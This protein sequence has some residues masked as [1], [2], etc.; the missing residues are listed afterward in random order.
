MSVAAGGKEKPDEPVMG[1][2]RGALIEE[3]RCA[4]LDEGAGA[5]RL[6]RSS[7]AGLRLPCNACLAL[8]T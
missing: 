4:R 7:S 3:E 6:S 5:P 1:H 2:D 8:Q